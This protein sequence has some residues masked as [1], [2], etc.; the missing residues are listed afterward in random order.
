MYL[1]YEYYK[2]LFDENKL[3]KDSYFVDPILKNNFNSS[4]LNYYMINDFKNNNKINIYINNF[5]KKCSL[6]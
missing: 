2:N 5:F 6:N 4:V 3:I 1:N